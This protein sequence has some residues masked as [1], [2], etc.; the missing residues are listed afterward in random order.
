MKNILLLLA[1]LLVSPVYAQNLFLANDGTFKAPISGGVTIT[2]PAVAGY[3]PIATSATAAA[4]SPLF[5][6]PNTWTALQTF[7]AGTAGTLPSG[8][9]QAFNFTQTPTGSTGG[10]SLLLNT[11]AIQSNTNVGGAFEV[12]WTVNHSFGGASALGGRTAITGNANLNAT[13]AVTNMN[14]N[15]VG[16]VGLGQSNVNDNGTSPAAAGTAAGG[17]F[18]T[19][20]VGRL[21]NAAA[22]SFLGVTAAEFNISIVTGASTWAKTLAQFSAE[23]TDRVQGTVVDTMLWLYNQNAS[24]PGWNTGLLFDGLNQVWPIK[25]TGTILQTIGSGT[26]AH[27]IDLSA[28]T[29]SADAF[30]S[31]GYAVAPNGALSVGPTTG[32]VWQRPASASLNSIP[33]DTVVN[34]GTFVGTGV[35]GATY[36][37]SVVSTGWNISSTIE[38]P[39]V[40][41][42]A[43]NFDTWE[44][45]FHLPGAGDYQ[46][47]RHFGLIDTASVVHRYMSFSLPWDGVG[48]VGGASSSVAI[49][50][51]QL[52]RLGFNNWAGT[53]VLFMNLTGNAL[54]INNSFQFLVSNNN[55]GTFRQ[56]NAAANAFL[57]LPYINAS[58]QTQ[59]DRPISSGVN[60]TVGGQLT[61]NGSTS[62]NVGLVPNATAT[63]LNI[64]QPIEIGFTTAILGKVTLDG[65]TSGQTVLSGTATGGH[66]SFAGS[67][68]APTNNACTGF[69]LGTGSTDIAGRVTFTSATSCAINFG[70]AFANAPFCNVTPG[71]AATPST[72][73]V[74]TTT[75]V[76][77]ATFTTAQTS[78]MYNCF[79]A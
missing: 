73:D 72:V 30:K 35:G 62:G 8:L 49:G 4:W 19:N 57:Q 74:T 17:V 68:T 25:S 51:I 33:F 47:E 26:A 9:T 59:I 41:G 61:L 65:S 60:G 46:I 2:G 71:T 34:E 77:T 44:S 11:L 13:T 37:D 42:V 27:G 36:V 63:S 56:T 76:L 67:G 78:M 38:V 23:P 75:A 39:A 21:T 18:G 55:V 54:N 45:K 31:A 22:T 16:V 1:L 50:T 28:T 7:N 14:R 20:S 70:T 69:A 58:D 48:A 10:S 79:G 29:F 52:D 66:L 5:T 53:Q 32:V 12:G 6:V 15:Y 43:A 64:T 40:A 3:V 24:N